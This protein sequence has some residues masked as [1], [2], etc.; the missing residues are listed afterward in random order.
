MKLKHVLW[1]TLP[2][3]L[4]Y[5]F[6]ETFTQP[7]VNDLKGDF[8]EVSFIRNENNT[9]PVQ[10]IYAVSV[11]DTL[12]SEME[13]YGKLMP[14]TKYGTTKVFFFATGTSSPEELNLEPDHFTNDFKPNCLAS[15]EKNGMGTISFKKYP[16]GK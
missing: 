3:L 5:V 15:F 10:R 8:Q 12:W 13:K 16:F 4:I 7:G 6:W 14:H 9:G 2:V 11:S 1:V